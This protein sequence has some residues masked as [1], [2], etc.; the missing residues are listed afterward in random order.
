[1]SQPSFEQLG[2]SVLKK[3]WGWYFA[4]GFLL[5]ILGTIALGRTYLFTTFSVVF[6][7]WLMLAAGVSQMMFACTR[8]RGWGGFLLGLVTG[9]LYIVAGFMMIFNPGATAV[10]LTLLIAM[11][12]LFDGIFRVIT[13]ITIRVPHRVWLGLSGLLAVLLGIAIW[14]QWPYSGIWVIGLFVGIHM[15]FNGWSVVMLALA[16]KNLPDDVQTGSAEA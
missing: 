2:L 5:V 9:V 16:A 13:A 7:G 10:A 6:L 3:N 15:I 1:M 4:L 14:R 8:E 11:F 12:L